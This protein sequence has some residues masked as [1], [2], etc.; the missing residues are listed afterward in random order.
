MD[1]HTCISQEL[2]F[3]LYKNEKTVHG[4]PTVYI[5]PK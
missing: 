2:Y 1:Q 4:T 3:H 5:K